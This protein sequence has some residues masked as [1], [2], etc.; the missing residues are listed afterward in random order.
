MTKSIS[1]KMGMKEKSRAIFIN[2][3]AGVLK[4]IDPP[5]LDKASRLNGN[6]DLIHVFAETEKDLRKKFKSLKNHLSPKGILWVSWPK[7]GQHG[8]DLSLSEIIKIGYYNGLVESKTLSINSSWSAIKFTH[9][10]KGKVYHNRY[11][12]LKGS[13]ESAAHYTP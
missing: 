13:D 10:K 3:P 12:K 7:S 8:T 11:G 4:D 1:A 2:A 5:S 6:F 9:P